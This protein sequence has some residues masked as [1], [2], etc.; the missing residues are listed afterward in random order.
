MLQPAHMVPAAAGGAV[1]WGHPKH[2][3]PHQLHLQPMGPC[4]SSDAAAVALAGTV[5]AA[6]VLEAVAGLQLWKQNSAGCC[7]M[8]QGQAGLLGLGP[9][10]AASTTDVDNVTS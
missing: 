6:V 8:L 4:H 1:S 9:A 7:L 3:L 5:A 10:H 2:C